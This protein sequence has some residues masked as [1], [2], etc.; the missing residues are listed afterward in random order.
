[1]LAEPTIVW[2][3]PQPYV[4]RRE[5]ITMTEFA[6]VAD[7][8][9]TMFDW[10]GGRGVAPA[11]APFFRY[12]VIDMSAELIVEAGIPVAVPLDVDEPTFVDVLP[13]GRYATLTHIGHP[14][15]LMSVTAS[16][17]DWAQQHGLRWDAT[18]TPEGEVWGARLE[19]MLTDPAEE[20]DMH[21][22]ETALLFR[23]ADEI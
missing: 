12:R 2:R 13:A 7:H 22:W 10:L 9:P 15:E 4:G 16:L 3:E 11:G 14:D 23:L 19:I 21:R 6:Q 18:P 17:L 8:L 5:S 20:P 1:M